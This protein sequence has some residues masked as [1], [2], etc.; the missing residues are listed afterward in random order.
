MVRPA[1]CALGEPDVAERDEATRSVSQRGAVSGVKTRFGGE[2]TCSR[3]LGTL[4][5]ICVDGLA[6]GRAVILT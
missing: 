3:V 4:P 2:R 1:P 6:G 5:D